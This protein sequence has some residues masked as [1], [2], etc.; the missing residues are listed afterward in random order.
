M[1]VW[2]NGRLNGGNETNE[3][4]CVAMQPPP[5][6]GRYISRSI[7]KILTPTN[8]LSRFGHLSDTAMFNT[9]ST[10]P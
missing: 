2:C 4:N 1:T 9:K 6:N 10:F 5:R 3:L 8:V 7:G